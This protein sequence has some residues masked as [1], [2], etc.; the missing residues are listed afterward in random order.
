MKKKIPSKEG[1]QDKISRREFLGLSKTVAIGGVIAA[2]VVGGVAGYL[3]G[4]AAAPAVTTAPASTITTTRVETREVTKTVTAPVARKLKVGY[5]YV[6]PIGDYGWT[7]G[8]DRGRRWADEKFGLNNV[9]SIY[10]ESVPEA[11]AAGA[12]KSLIE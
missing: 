11:E 4:S 7:H 8:H 6:G 5:V 3:A 2:G 9:E 1:L 10:I 12:I